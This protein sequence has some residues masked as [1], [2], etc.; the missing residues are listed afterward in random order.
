MLD[1]LKFLEDEGGFTIALGMNESQNV[2]T[3]LP[4][5]F[6]SKPSGDVSFY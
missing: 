6:A 4:S 1:L 5:I 2:M 3:F